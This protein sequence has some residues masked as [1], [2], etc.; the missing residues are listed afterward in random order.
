VQRG[1]GS[2]RAALLAELVAKTE[3]AVIRGEAPPGHLAALRRLQAEDLAAA[4]GDPVPLLVAQVG[5]CFTGPLPLAFAEHLLADS[6]SDW[7][8][9]GNLTRLRILVCDR[10]FE[11]GFEVQNL[12]EAGRTAPSLGVLLET[13]YPDNLAALRLLW[14]QRASQ[15][16]GRCGPCVTAFEVAADRQRARLL[17]RYPD[18][19][20]LQEEPKWPPIGLIGRE[21]EQVRIVL[22]ARGVYLQD[23]LFA[24]PPLI[25]DVVLRPGGADITFG[26]VRFQA[27]GRLE[28]LAPRMDHWF[29]FA[30]EDFLPRLRAV[31]AW[32]PP[33]HEALLRAWGAVPCPECRRPLLAR[34]GDIGVSAE[35]AVSERAS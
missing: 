8:S 26:G 35:E 28:A 4:N 25:T 7:C 13:M 24:E 2:L 11:A 22:C 16:W 21:P 1:Y 17:G 33:E 5:H 27:R 19:L 3:A 31:R 9:R 14:S 29:R 12:L 34:V 23:T 30:F 18:L 10:A 15:P 20:L 6:S 32:K